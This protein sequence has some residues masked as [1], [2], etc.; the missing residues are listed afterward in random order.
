M[1]KWVSY[2]T[3]P[4][5]LHLLIGIAEAS[6][7]GTSRTWP[8][9][10]F[11]RSLAQEFTGPLPTILGIFGIVGSAFSLYSGH[12]GEGTRKFL[13]LILVVSIALTAPTLIS[14]LTSDAGGSASGAILGGF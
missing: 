10:T 7:G 12:A 1:K 2:S 5:V 14:W 11:L 3:V 4:L 6:A 9:T 13:I 8:W